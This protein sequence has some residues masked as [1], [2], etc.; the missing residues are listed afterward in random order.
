MTLQEIIKIVIYIHVITG[1]L[2]MIAGVI[3]MIAKK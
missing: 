3:A 1:T 2:A